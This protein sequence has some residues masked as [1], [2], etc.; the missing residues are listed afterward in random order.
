M[1]ISIGRRSR[2]TALGAGL[3]TASAIAVSA[4]G[5]ALADTADT[6]GSASLAVPVAVVA[7]LANA[8][9]VMLPGTPATSTF[10]P[11]AGTDTVTN[12]VT[13]GNAE[14]RNFTG[15]LKLGGSLVVI[16]ARTGKSVNITGLQV[17]LFTGAFQGVLPGNTTVTSLAYLNG[18]MSTSSDPGPPATETLTCSALSL[19]T[20]AAT[21]LNT[22]LGVTRVFR[23][24]INI[25]SF[26][27]TFDVTVT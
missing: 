5:P 9:I 23:H 1:H 13:G 14:L 12:P 6:G 8:N 11:T 26:T 2:L 20:K 21:A 15:I 4:S 27:T 10:D 22:D 24:G 19:S 17:N 25:G 18:V 16:D 3:I 7:G